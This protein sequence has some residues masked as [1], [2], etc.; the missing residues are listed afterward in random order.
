MTAKRSR[1]AHDEIQIP[2][3]P[4]AVAV[5][6]DNGGATT[7]SS[8]TAHGP[9]VLYEGAQSS[10]GADAAT[11]LVASALDLQEPR[12]DQFTPTDP[13][14]LADLLVDRTGLLARTLPFATNHSPANGV[15]VYT[16]RAALHFEDDPA[17]MAALF[18][19]ANIESVSV[20]KARVYQSADPAGAR[21]VADALA[22]NASDS[23]YRTASGPPSL[24]AAR[25]F[26]GGHGPYE[27]PRRFYCVAV[28]DRYAFE[29]FS[30]R[31]RDAHQ[32]IAAQYRMLL[33][34]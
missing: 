6:V 11:A 27:V 22:A 29:V 4:Q 33:S 8:L 31:E 7:V 17:R 20:S 16:P 18:Q 19:A 28:A 13:S 2:G 23:G 30:D 24:A 21:R 5:R 32:H 9:Y 3:H 34:P 14:R 10:S 26:D 1:R 15:A 12:I 25:C